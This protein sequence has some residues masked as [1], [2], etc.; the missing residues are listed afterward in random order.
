MTGLAY[1]GSERAELLTPRVQLQQKGRCLD[2]TTACV[3]QNVC[4]VG[5]DAAATSKTRA[6]KPRAQRGLPHFST[7]AAETS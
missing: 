2:S 5:G 6:S 1:P 3:H 7:G 4:S